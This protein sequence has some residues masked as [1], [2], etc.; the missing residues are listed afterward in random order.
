MLD[1]LKFVKGA[2]SGKNL[3]P[4]VTHFKIKDQRITGFNGRVALSAPI[5]IEFDAAPEGVTFIKAIEQCKDATS[6]TL[7]PAGRIKVHSGTFKAF[8]RCHDG[9]F[10]E[11]G[12]A[13]IAIENPGKFLEALETIYPFMG[14]DASRPWSH[15]VMIE[16]PF[17]YATNNIVLIKVYTGGN[18]PRLPIPSDTVRE[19]IRIGMEP[20]HLQTD[21]NTVTFLYEDGRWITSILLADEGWP[22]QEVQERLFATP[23]TLI[24][25]PEGLF[26]NISRLQPFLPEHNTFVKL[27]EDGIKTTNYDGGEGGAMIDFPLPGANI[28]FT[29]K[30]IMQVG[31]VAKQFDPVDRGTPSVFIGEMC[32]GVIMPVKQ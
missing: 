13:G 23:C 11:M 5:D 8:V 12:P 21:G 28:T 7:T 4:Q 14:E 2:L 22:P 29:Y 20:T 24:D 19:L 10:Y 30:Y 16:G 27:T 15:G 3:D 1:A 18:Y 31:T 6:L 17:V 32:M 9:I 25:V 26:E